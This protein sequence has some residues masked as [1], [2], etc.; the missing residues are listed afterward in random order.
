MANN[1][2]DDNAVGP[3]GTQVFNLDDINKMIDAKV[4][5][6]QSKGANV[7]AL[8]GI[9]DN[10]KD[11]TFVLS[12][13]K[14]EIGRRPSSDVVVNVSSVSAIHAQMHNEGGNW[15]VVN[16]LSSNGTFVNG[17]KVSNLYVNAG[18]R[19]SFAGA[20]FIFTYIDAA[21][22][23]GTKKGNGLVIGLI[24]VAAIAAGAYYAWANQLI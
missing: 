9:S 14:V 10:V 2:K 11:Q 8:V 18:D 1:D 16:L 24:V 22:S 17:K 3:Q 6:Q 12:G 21:K 13:D 4:A 23:D 7:P 15:K 19:I 5:E 20:E